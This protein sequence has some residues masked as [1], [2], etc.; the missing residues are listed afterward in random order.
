LSD[1]GLSPR[2]VCA[3]PK[4]SAIFEKLLL[5]SPILAGKKTWF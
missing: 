5:D 2:T 3:Y 1:I 4:S